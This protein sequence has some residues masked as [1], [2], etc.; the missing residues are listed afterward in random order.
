MSEEPTYRSIPE[1]LKT[2][3]GHKPSHHEFV[4]MIIRDTNDLPASER[5]RLIQGLQK[6]PEKN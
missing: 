6:P 5:M 1:Q 3:T 2:L 4:D